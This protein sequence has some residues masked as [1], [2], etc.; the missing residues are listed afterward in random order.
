LCCRA[1]PND[2]SGRDDRS[3][4]LW[5]KARVGEI[6]DE[7]RCGDARLGSS[8]RPPRDG[9]QRIPAARTLLGVQRGRARGAAPRLALRGSV[10]CTLQVGEDPGV[11]ERRKQPPKARIRSSEERGEVYRPAPESGTSVGAR[12]R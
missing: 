1:V 11:G 4:R 8:R 2:R 12:T 7:S 6:Q 3:A 5:L 9:G 10:Q